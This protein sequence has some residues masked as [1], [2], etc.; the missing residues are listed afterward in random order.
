MEKSDQLRSLAY[1]LSVNGNSFCP[2]LPKV[3]IYLIINAV[4]N[5]N[6][7][8]MSFLTSKA[9]EIPVKDSPMRFCRGNQV[10]SFQYIC[11]SL[12]IITVKD[13]GSF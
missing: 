6:T 2:G 12:R 7:S 4:L 3:Q 1:S 13:V 9:Y 8:D 11:F 5:H 10:K